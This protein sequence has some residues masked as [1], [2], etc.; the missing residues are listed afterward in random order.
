MKKSY[1]YVGV[2]AERDGEARQEHDGRTVQARLD[3]AR[4]FHQ[5]PIHGGREMPQSQAAP[6][7]GQNWPALRHLQ[8]EL[9][10]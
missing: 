10:H 3:A 6:C 9:L 2:I 8:T 4:L 1:R 5:R 7:T